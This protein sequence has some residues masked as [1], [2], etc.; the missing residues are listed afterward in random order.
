MQEVN[1]VRRVAEVRCG[2]GASGIAF[3]SNDASDARL[4]R[5]RRAE[6]CCIHHHG[7]PSCSRAAIATFTGGSSLHYKTKDL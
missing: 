7:V 6:V 5:P 3:G 2:Q 4:E 1:A